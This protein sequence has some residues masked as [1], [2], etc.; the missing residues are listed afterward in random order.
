M[1]APVS[2]TNQFGVIGIGL[3]WQHLASAIMFLLTICFWL[4]AILNTE[5]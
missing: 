4:T 3:S 1:S 2:I 5:N